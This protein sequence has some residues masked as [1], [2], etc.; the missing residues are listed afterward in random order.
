MAFSLKFSKTIFVFLHSFTV[1]K[2]GAVGGEW[3]SFDLH[4]FN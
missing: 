2:L 4:D 1:F 3:Q